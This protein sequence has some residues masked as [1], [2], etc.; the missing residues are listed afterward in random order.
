MGVQAE[1][2]DRNGGRKARDERPCG[3][4]EADTGGVGEPA[5]RGRKRVG[6]GG[7]A[8]RLEQAL[9][10]QQALGEAVAELLP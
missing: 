6:A 9:G 4:L 1:R 3:G 2:A 5:Q 7:L 8:E 10:E